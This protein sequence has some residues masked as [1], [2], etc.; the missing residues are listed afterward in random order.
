MTFY[1]EGCTRVQL[2]K[3]KSSSFFFPL[4][5]GIFDDG[6]SESEYDFIKNNRLSKWT[7][8]LYFHRINKTMID[9]L[10]TFANDFSS[11]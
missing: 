4:F 5:I 11:Y 8:Y 2:R 7:I 1:H 9:K 6:I 10:K 3:P